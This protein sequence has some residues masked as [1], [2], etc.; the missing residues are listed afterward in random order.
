MDGLTNLSRLCVADSLSCRKVGK[1][2]MNLVLFVLFVVESLQRHLLNPE[3]GIW[4]RRRK[5]PTIASVKHV[6]FCRCDCK[7]EEGDICQLLS[8]QPSQLR[9]NSSNENKFIVVGERFNFLSGKQKDK[10]WIVVL[11]NS[12]TVSVH[13]PRGAGLCVCV[14]MYVRFFFSFFFL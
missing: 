13:I 9:S 5:S 3:A 12:F 1:L 11:A 6:V 8:R 4:N 2:R 10:D 14:Y 7:I